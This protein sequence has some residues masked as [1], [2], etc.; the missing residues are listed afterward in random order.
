[1]PLNN[2]KM[3]CFILIK[4]LVFY[5]YIGNKVDFNL[6][7]PGPN[8]CPIEIC[9]WFLCAMNSGMRN[10]LQADPADIQNFCKTR[11]TKEK[12]KTYGLTS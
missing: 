10:A 3:L 12:V 6:I 8:E 4:H 2:A 1:M 5:E 7:L 11:K 9:V